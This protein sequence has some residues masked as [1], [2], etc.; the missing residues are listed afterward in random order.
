MKLDMRV[1]EH[2]GIKLYSNAAAVLS[3]L[4]ANSWDADATMVRVS[5]ENEKITISDNG[6][7]M[8]T[9]ELNKRFL[10]V[11]YDKR[12]SEGSSSGKFERRFMGRKGIG[13]LSVFSI[14]RCV[15]VYSA[16][17]A[18]K[19]GLRL[20]LSAIETA[21]K[22]DAEYH[23]EELVYRED[24][25]PTGTTIELTGLKKSRV[26][27]TAAALRKRLA[28]RFAI[29][30]REGLN[31]DRFDVTINNSPIGPGDRDDLKA[32]EYLWEL[33]GSEV[34]PASETP[35]LRKRFTVADNKAGSNQDWMVEGWFGASI[36]PSDLDKDSD[37]GNLRSLVV[38]SRGR[39]IQENI[40]DK[41]GFNGVFGSYLTGQIHADFLDLD[42]REDIATSDRQRLIEDDERVTALLAY[43]RKTVVDAADQ[44]ASLRREARSEEVETKQPVLKDW[45]NG[46]PA[47]QQVA[48]RNMMGLIQELDIDAAKESDRKT[49]FRSGVLAF[50]RLRLREA[51]HNF[52]NLE[53]LSAEQM[54]N[55]LATQDDLEASLYRDIIA[56]RIE[57]IRQF[58]NLTDENE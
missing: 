26:G 21:I 31:G 50:E 22:S 35:K 15:D 14:A 5:L 29:I 38:L 57:A 46:L 53:S 34:I 11:G 27:T 48:A 55:L 4:V 16:S 43:L 44:W 51:S 6:N 23:P 32:I 33:G 9:E 12:K 40:L 18:E 3:E 37:A 41:L 8:T 54:L 28:R 17:K 36:K 58:K 45:I 24:L 19:N 7:G 52:E 1:L 39:L 2:L 13:K 56:A 20:E 10:V 49:L 30:G 47:S 25:A 42:D